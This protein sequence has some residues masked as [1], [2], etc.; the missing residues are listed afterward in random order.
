MACTVLTKADHT[1]YI[2][3]C[4]VGTAAYWLATDEGRA[5]RLYRTLYGGVMQP[6]ELLLA[7]ANDRIVYYS[8]P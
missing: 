6:T 7:T 1:D 8:G 2:G 4:M 5:H 3:L